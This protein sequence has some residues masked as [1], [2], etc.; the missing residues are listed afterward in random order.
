MIIFLLLVNLGHKN[1]NSKD[2]KFNES[3]QQKLSLHPALFVYFI[4]LFLMSYHTILYYR[5]YVYF[6]LL[7]LNLPL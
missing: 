1:K 2:S 7:T 3:N 5:S 4:Y 6:Y